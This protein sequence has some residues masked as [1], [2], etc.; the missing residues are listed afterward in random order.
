MCMLH[1]PWATP[2]KF[3]VGHLVKYKPTGHFVLDM[4]MCGL[5]IALAFPFGVLQLCS[6][7]QKRNIS[8]SCTSLL[9]GF[10][11]CNSIP[12][13]FWEKVPRSFEIMSI[14]LIKKVQTQK[15][16]I[17]LVGRL[18]KRK[19]KVLINSSNYFMYIIIYCFRQQNAHFIV[20]LSSIWYW[21][22]PKNLH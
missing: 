13:K 10:P 5:H 14:N 7:M 11:N 3:F 16:Q 9:V 2:I 21:L 4:A 22:Q 6:P 15:D 19:K 12:V 18:K 1:G 8:G 20:N 17:F